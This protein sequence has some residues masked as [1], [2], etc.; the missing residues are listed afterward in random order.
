MCKKNKAIEKKVVRSLYQRLM[1][2]ITL[3]SLIISLEKM[4]KKGNTGMRGSH[5]TQQDQ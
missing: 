1:T 2:G 4:S 3:M 5:Y